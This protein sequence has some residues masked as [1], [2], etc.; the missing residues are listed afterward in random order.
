[1]TDD[2]W[3]H[4]GMGEAYWSHGP[5]L[6]EDPFLFTAEG[7][8]T[9]AAWLAD[10]ALHS[11]ERVFGFAGLR[12][13]HAL[14]VVLVLW[15]AARLLHSTSGSPR[16]AGLGIAVFGALAAYRLV[17]LRPH[18]FTILATLILARMFV[19]DRRVPSWPRVAA[20]GG[21]CLVWANSHA[22]FPLGP[23]LLGLAATHQAALDWIRERACGART[24]RLAVLVVVAGLA[25]L[26]NPT[27]PEALLP[28]VKAGDS[29]PDLSRI[30]DEWAPLRLLTFPVG[31]PPPSPL[32]WLLVWLLMSGLAASL[33]MHVRACRDDCSVRVREP[34]DLLLAALAL[35]GLLAMLLAVRFTWLC[36]FAL[37]SIGSSLRA[38]G[39]LE[40][41]RL[42]LRI[43]LAAASLSVAAAFVVAGVWPAIAQ[44]RSVA[45]Y[46]QPY[47]AGKY[48]AHAV[49]FLRD[50]GLEGRLWNGYTQGSFL[51]S[52]LR[53]QLQV[54]LNGSLNVPPAVFRD[55]FAITAGVGEAAEILDRHRV[56]IFFGTG[57]PVLPT[58]GRQ[59]QFDTTARVAGDPAWLL[60]FRNAMSAVY[61]R[62]GARPENVER[63]VRYYARA[64]VGFD[65]SRG[66]DPQRTLEENPRWAFDHGLV[67]ADLLALRRRARSPDPMRAAPAQ[68]LLAHVY[69]L[70]GLDEAAARLD[71]A[72]LSADPQARGAARRLLG[73]AIRA[74]DAAAIAE[75]LERLD[76]VAGPKLALDLEL[77]R[78]GR[79]ALEQ[80]GLRPRPSLLESRAVASLLG[81]YRAPEARPR[82]SPAGS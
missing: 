40:A 70:L 77:L 61:L 32:G 3:W 45:A 7:P 57:M 16:F 67:P 52:W 1:M 30:V 46:A 79:S 19:V 71:G 10:L 64:G 47:A 75:G 66:F 24:R 43:A 25:T 76:A 54:F 26:A 41:S 69:L 78:A 49:W 59:P 27:G 4:L 38:C 68:E 63:V 39:W 42:R 53:P 81:R 12:W 62:R 74:G 14:A 82:R 29:T 11:V 13:G 48:F 51:G 23:L 15:Q 58:P 17:Q 22:A 31:P 37:L 72:R 28:T 55:G 20:G 2:T 56:D 5:W 8:P 9:P 73:V 21:L 60:V 36:I 35:L 65:P 18:L 50:A 6:V 33:A 80:P 34:P 44:V